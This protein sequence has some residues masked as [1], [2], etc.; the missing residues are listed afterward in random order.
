MGYTQARLGDVTT[1]TGSGPGVL[2]QI[3]GWITATPANAANSPQVVQDWMAAVRLRGNA[4]VRYPKTDDI[5]TA[6]QLAEKEANRDDAGNVL[7][8]SYYIAPPEVL[9][10][11]STNRTLSQA[12]PTVAKI[13]A[14]G[15]SPFDDIQHAIVTG[16]LI[17]G[18]LFLASRFIGGRR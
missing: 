8:Y 10:A 18:G 4:V 11:D 12:A 5:G 9:A 1:P 3:W 7:G 6:G 17:I 13:A 15:E 2:S 14:V 16:G